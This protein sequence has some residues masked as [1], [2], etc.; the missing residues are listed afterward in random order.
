MPD[1]A[2][3]VKITL[4]FSDDG[5]V[6]IIDQ[7]KV[8]TRE[9]GETTSQASAKAASGLEHLNTA[10]LKVG[11][12]VTAT[13][14]VIK[15]ATDFA[16]I[17]AMAQQ[18]EE[19]FARVTRSL[20]VYGDELISK[21]TE[22][23]YTFVDRTNV[24]IKAQRALVEGLSPDQIIKI[25]EASRVASRLM[26]VTVEEAFNRVIEAVITLQTRGLKQAFPMDQ[27]LV[28][29]RYAE[30][31]GTIAERLT[32]AGK[33]QAIYNE[34]IR[35][36][37]ERVEILGD[38]AATA[39]EKIQALSSSF[40]EFKSIAG[41]TF[42]ETVWSP[43]FKTMNTFVGWID[44]G[45]TKIE[46]LNTAI[47]KGLGLKKVPELPPEL[48]PSHGVQESELLASHAPWSKE[49][50]QEEIDYKKLKE[51]QLQLDLEYQGKYS[52]LINDRIGALKIEKDQ[53]IANAKVKGLEISAIEKYYSEAE[54]RVVFESLKISSQKELKEIAEHT[55]RA[56]E[57]IKANWKAGT[58]SVADYVNALKAASDAMK[59]LTGEDISKEKEEAWDKNAETIKGISKDEEGWL[60]KVDKA[61][62]DLFKT[63][64]DLEKLKIPTHADVGPMEREVNA[65]KE[66]LRAEGL[67]IPVTTAET[68][69]V[70]GSYM[71]T[72]EQTGNMGGGVEWLNYVK[73]GGMGGQID[74][75]GI[76][77][78][79][80]RISGQIRDA[81]AHGFTI[82][83]YM[84][85]S[86]R[87]PFSEKIRE[88][89]A[90]FG[91]LGK[92]L[93]GI[94]AEIN[95][96][97]LSAEYKKLETKLNQVERILPDMSAMAS[98]TGGNPYVG[99]P[100]VQ[101]VKDLT[102]EYTEQLKI[103]QMKMD[104]QMLKGYG[105]SM[106]TGGIVPFTGLYQLHVGE[107]VTPS[108]LRNV[109]S[110]ISLAVNISGVNDPR[111]IGNDIVKILK[112]NLNTELN[113]LLKQR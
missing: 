84:E 42:L 85:G 30:S 62:D 4:Q 8:K 32:E 108:T 48:L 11:A 75:G 111:E 60:K 65:M 24:M 59:K 104:Y 98:A 50:K 44:A 2:N 43:A 78:A 14:L 70:T 51:D 76:G 36:Y 88:M 103:L 64:K 5:T 25:T 110:N 54:T 16:N 31:I 101:T 69:G 9:L 18:A 19:S 81:E 45:I 112:Y 41:E 27:E 20:G 13:Y 74:I 35:L 37:K 33:R 109:S 28:F 57:I 38:K 17:G 46:S 77:A 105:G 34:I 7:A 22:A 90:E 79:I 100:I 96:A 56:A 6:K 94:E 66:K 92:A 91:G 15:K 97:E 49:I 58:S 21:M 68:S 1:N 72:K 26:G 55:M 106:Q 40:S 99:G 83:V 82:P 71:T 39:S 53:A 113:N 87:K 10:W 3:T 73:G 12:G 67:I 29:R 107:T 80:D 52:Q 61:N 95:V 102:A 23:S 93:S 47:Q 89:I 86:T 63:L